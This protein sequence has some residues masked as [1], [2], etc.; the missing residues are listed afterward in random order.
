MFTV[1]KQTDLLKTYRAVFPNGQRLGS[2]ALVFL[3][4]VASRVSEVVENEIQ[5]NGQK[6]SL[7]LAAETAK[8]VSS[9]ADVYGDGEG[10]AEN[11]VK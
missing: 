8:A 4:D 2:D 10:Q 1:Y 5:E 7:I 3:N 6:V 9:V 11:V